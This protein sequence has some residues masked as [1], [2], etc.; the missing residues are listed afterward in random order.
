MKED[1][2][3]RNNWKNVVAEKNSP[4]EIWGDV[5]DSLKYWKWEELPLEGELFRN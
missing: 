3:L 4:E 5:H 2:S 1:G